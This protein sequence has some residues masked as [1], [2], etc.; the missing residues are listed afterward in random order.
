[1]SFNTERE[2]VSPAL[3]CC[4]VL[5]EMGNPF[6]PVVMFTSDCHGRNA[7]KT[8]GLTHTHV[9]THMHTLLSSFGSCSK[10]IFHNTTVSQ[11]TKTFTYSSLLFNTILVYKRHQ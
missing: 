7:T 4:V 5:L 1:M 11:R 10:E 6:S 8:F 2:T 3:L 9:H